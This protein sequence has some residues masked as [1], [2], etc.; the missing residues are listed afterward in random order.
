MRRNLPVSSADH[1]F[2]YLMPVLSK[3]FIYLTMFYLH[4]LVLLAFPS[5]VTRSRVDEKVGTRVPFFLEFVRCRRHTRTARVFKVV[6]A[7]GCVSSTR[8]DLC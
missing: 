2:G 5:C 1:K 6:L 8:V 7:H 3:Q 4:I